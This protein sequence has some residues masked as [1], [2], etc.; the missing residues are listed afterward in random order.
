MF[1]SIFLSL[2]LTVVWYGLLC[3]MC[4]NYEYAHDR[5]KSSTCVCLSG[6]LLLCF[7]PRMR[8]LNSRYDICAVQGCTMPRAA[9]LRKFKFTLPTVRRRERKKE[10]LAMIS[11]RNKKLNFWLKETKEKK[12]KQMFIPNPSSSQS[13]NLTTT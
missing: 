3:C 6:C 9:S 4:T 7:G 10:N 1:D 2:G 11:R 12:R 5:V 8:M 13:S